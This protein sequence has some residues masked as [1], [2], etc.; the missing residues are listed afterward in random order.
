MSCSSCSSAVSSQDAVR[1]VLS[2]DQDPAQTIDCM[3]LDFDMLILNGPEDYCNASKIWLHGNYPRS[4]WE[5]GMSKEDTCIFER[6]MAP[7]T[8]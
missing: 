7:T 4:D 5:F 3:M 1:I 8:S 6:I 2:T